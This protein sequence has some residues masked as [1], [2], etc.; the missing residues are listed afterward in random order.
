MRFQS[1]A[2]ETLETS[3]L[4]LYQRIAE[5][6]TTQPNAPLPGPFGP[7]LLIP[8]I[9][10]HLCELGNALRFQ[11]HFL[12]AI[13]EIGILVTARWWR[14]N[15]EW[16]A[17]APMAREAGVT[18]TQIEQIKQG[19]RPIFPEAPQQIAFDA[20]NE[21]V[22]TRTLSET[23]FKRLQIELGEKGSINFV[24]LI[25]Y[26]LSVSAMLNAF[27]IQVPTPVETPFPS[28]H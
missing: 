15:F 23:T 5:T 18:D 28:S 25:G 17:H 8:E 2:P 16:Y 27:D 26:Y 19:E 11:S 6:R 22:E 7:W 10:Q 21:L 24:A 1:P 20:A 12:R 4:S 9:G 3:Q 13:M 14:S